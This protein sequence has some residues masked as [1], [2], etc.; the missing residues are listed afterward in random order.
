VK[1]MN[2]TEHLFFLIQQKKEEFL[3]PVIHL[4][5]A[6]QMLD[7]DLIIKSTDYRINTMRHQSDVEVMDQVNKFCSP[8]DLFLT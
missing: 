6:K 8:I 3:L 7:I 4:L 5:K 2:S 1:L